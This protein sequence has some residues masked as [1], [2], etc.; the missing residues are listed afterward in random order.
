MRWQIV[1]CVALPPLEAVE[2]KASQAA[3]R[4]IAGGDDDFGGKTDTI[5]GP[6]FD[7]N[8]ARRLSSAAQGKA[9]TIDSGS[10]D[11]SRSSGSGSGKPSS[12]HP[13]G[14]LIVLT[15]SSPHP[16]NPHLV[17]TS[18]CHRETVALPGGDGALIGVGVLTGLM[19]ILELKHMV[20]KS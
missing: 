14:I 13:H 2:E 20:S 15:S 4:K 5:D 12:P 9:G 18:S 10:F 19:L 7:Y 11:Y 1:A 16:R 8:R 17:L 3:L 6:S